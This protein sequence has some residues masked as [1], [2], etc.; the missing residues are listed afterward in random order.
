VKRKIVKSQTPHTIRYS[1]IPALYPTE[2]APW[3]ASP[4]AEYEFAMDQ[5]GVCRT[6]NESQNTENMPITI[7]EKKLPMI[8]S[9]IVARRRRIGPVK[10]KIPL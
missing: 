9:K 4:V 1:A 7:M 5:E 2:A 8:H 6:P 3:A 10:K